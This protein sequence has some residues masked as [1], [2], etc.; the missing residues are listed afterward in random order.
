[1]SAQN[2]GLTAAF[3]LGL[4]AAGAIALLLGVQWLTAEPVAARKMQRYLSELQQLLPGIPIQVAETQ[5]LAGKHFAVDQPVSLLTLMQS[6][7]RLAWVFDLI[8]PHGYS[9]D[10]RLLVALEPQQGRVLGIR[11]LEHRET[12][13]LG[14]RIEPQHSP[15]LKQFLG[16]DATLP[17]LAWR[18]RREGGR[19]DSLSGATISALA[20][21]K[22][23]HR[24]SLFYVAN[25][26]SLP[27]RH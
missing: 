11:I 5:V 12:P 1:M 17:T 24:C 19:L 2:L 21:R 4:L 6:Q 15:W 9:G 3:R 8:T 10:I 18:W 22:A 7:Q 20:V 26:Q 13:G 14:D 16:L 27:T 25:L 23:I